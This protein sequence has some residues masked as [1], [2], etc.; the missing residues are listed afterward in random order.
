MRSTA[1]LTYKSFSSYEETLGWVRRLRPDSIVSVRLPDLSDP[2][3]YH[4]PGWLGEA[5]DDPGGIAFS[6]SIEK[7]LEQARDKRLVRMV[8][9]LLQ[10]I[11]ESDLPSDLA[12][13]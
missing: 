11:E 1:V 13:L 5:P 6:H 7:D 3:E 10:A 2:S 8:G 4:L 12:P 9:W